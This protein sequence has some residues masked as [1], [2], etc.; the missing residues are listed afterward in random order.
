MEPNR[1]DAKYPQND[2]FSSGQIESMIFQQKTPRTY[3]LSHMRFSYSRLPWVLVRWG[4]QGNVQKRRH[5]SNGRGA[6]FLWNDLPSMRPIMI[7]S[8]VST[9]Q[10]ASQSMPLIYLMEKFKIY[11]HL[12]PTKW[13]VQTISTFIAHKINY[14]T[15]SSQGQGLLLKADSDRASTGISKVKHKFNQVVDQGAEVVPGLLQRPL[16]AHVGVGL[17]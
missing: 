4:F 7:A 1:G 12:L 6:F 8:F 3:F 9:V 10:Q 11:Q 15:G 5:H 2:Q 16:H 14:K 13:K 17:Q